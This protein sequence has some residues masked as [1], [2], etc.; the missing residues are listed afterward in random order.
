MGCRQAPGWVEAAREAK[1]GGADT[2]VVSASS[3][4]CPD[5]TEQDVSDRSAAA[6]LRARPRLSA[7]ATGV[8]TAAGQGHPPGPALF[9][10]RPGWSVVITEVYG[11]ALSHFDR[12]RGQFFCKGLDS[13]YRRFS[14]APVWS[15]RHLLC[16][17]VFRIL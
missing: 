10:P 4:L 6:R 7:L 8:P 12:G 16:L 1:P 2:R 9:L 3:T 11:G 15:V 13:I 5:G 17:F 14:E